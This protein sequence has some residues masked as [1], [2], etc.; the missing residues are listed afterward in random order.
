MG[1]EQ[2]G[3]TAI[4][5]RWL[6]I[7]RTLCFVVNGDEVLLLKRAPTKRVFPNQYNGLGG[8]IE[9]NEDPFTSAKREIQEECGLE[10]D[11]LRLVAIHHINTQQQTGIMLFVFVG[12]TTQREVMDDEKEGTLEWVKIS[13]VKEYDLVE[14]LPLILPKYLNHRGSPLF[15]YVTYDENDHIQLAYAQG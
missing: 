3:A 7:P 12:Q 4:Q 13:K 5:G 6:T 15:V 10:I 11:D 14:D 8:H 2:Q 9:K 1:A